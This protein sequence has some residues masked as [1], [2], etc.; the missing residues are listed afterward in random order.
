MRVV[1]RS[2]AGAAG[3]T[4][5][6]MRRRHLR[7]VL[8][9]EAQD[10]HPGWSLGLFMSELARG[11]RDRR[12]VVAKVGGEVVGFAGILF[13]GAEGHVTTIAVDPR[14]RGE[15]VGTR[16]LLVL[17]REAVARGAE[18]MTLEV[19]A[20]NTP[21]IALYRRFGFIPAGVR[22]DYYRDLGE[23]ALVM[24]ASGVDTPEYRAR[25]D[26]IEASLPSPTV[27]EVGA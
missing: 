26:L 18:A 3:V 21:A 5:A 2:S 4:V 17:A 23:D 6:P 7:A 22:K 15:R 16:L 19:R 25:L 20:S 10:V 27:M 12:Y 1:A 8:R 11:S 24:W 14:R 9:I 13:V